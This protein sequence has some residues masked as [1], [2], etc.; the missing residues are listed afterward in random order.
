M[1]WA[2]GVVPVSRTKL[3]LSKR[4]G[5]VRK[6][7][8]ELKTDANNESNVDEKGVIK[9]NVGDGRDVERW[10]FSDWLNSGT[11]KQGGRKKEPALPV[12]KSAKWNSGDNPVLVASALIGLGV[13]ITSITERAFSMN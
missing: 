1:V 3:A 13:L 4:D 7:L 2:N 8:D 11:S 9:P 12:L 10:L 6:Y 5:D